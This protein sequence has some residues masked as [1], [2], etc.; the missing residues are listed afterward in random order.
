[1]KLVPYTVMVPEHYAVF[2]RRMGEILPD[3]E[4]VTSMEFVEDQVL[5]D[6]DRQFLDAIAWAVGGWDFDTTE[7]KIEAENL[8]LEACNKLVEGDAACEVEVAL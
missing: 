3:F 1:M 6:Q 2:M 4:Y 7:R 8:I 5:Q